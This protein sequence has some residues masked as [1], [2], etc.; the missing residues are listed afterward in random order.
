[1]TEELSHGAAGGLLELRREGNGGA[2]LSGR[3][4]YGKPAVLSDGGRNGRPVKEI[5]ERGAFDYTVEAADVDIHLLLGHSF[6]KPLASKRTGTLTFRQTAEALVIA[7]VLTPSILRTQHAQDALALVE[8]GLS[9][10][11][12]P[13]FRLPPER[14]VPREEAEVIEDEPDRPAE[15]MHRA[16]IRRIRQA[17]LVEMSL[18][19]RPAY[20]EASVDLARA[21]AAPAPVAP[22]AALV[23]R[24]RWRA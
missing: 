2:R 8:S 5:I 7:A 15:G 4:P 6:D 14:A 22:S 1:M 24:R 11:L 13:G 18:V 3:F 23:A 10:G 17:I 9:V 20:Q 12:S 16:I 21:M 19:T